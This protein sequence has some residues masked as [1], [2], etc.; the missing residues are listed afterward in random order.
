MKM[1]RPN[2]GG[3]SS[4]FPQP[5]G[6]D[7]GLMPDPALNPI[8]FWSEV[9]KRLDTAT[10]LGTDC[11]LLCG[12]QCCKGGPEDGMLLFPGEESL[13]APD[14]LPAGW[15]L[16]PSSLNVSLLVCSGTCARERRPLS[17]RIFPLLPRV[18]V[19]GR[20][21]PEVDL[22]AARVCPLLYDTGAPKLGPAFAEAVTHAFELAVHAPGVR[23]L[24]DLL[25]QENQALRRLLR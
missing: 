17:C 24:L 6:A 23:V 1:A 13:Y 19:R 12:A 16:L 15:T 4:F 7:A 5:G 10:P 8:A 14:T 11:G 9:H 22:R 2:R 25:W 18:D 3:K 21:H 20:I